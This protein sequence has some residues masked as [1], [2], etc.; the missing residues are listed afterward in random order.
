MKKTALL[1]CLVLAMVLSGCSNNFTFTSFMGK[2]T[3]EIK[4]DEGGRTSESDYF[5]LDKGKVLNV[6]S[7]L[8]EG[9]VQIDFVEAEVYLHEGDDPADVI[10][11]DTVD[12]I[13]AGPGD[14]QTVSLDPGDYVI[15]LTTIGKTNGKILVTQEKQ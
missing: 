4:D 5:T 15:Q 12:S 11:G 3:I 9:Q 8:A 13:T 10:L 6:E 2:I 14:S 1:C 7:S